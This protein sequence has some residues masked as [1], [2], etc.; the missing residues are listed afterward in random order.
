MGAQ[1]AA[2]GAVMPYVVIGALVVGAVIIYREEIGAAGAAVGE[3]AAATGQAVTDT[4]EAVITGYSETGNV[5]SRF[6]FGRRT[7]QVPYKPMIKPTGSL[8]EFYD[9]LHITGPADPGYGAP[10]DYPTVITPA[11]AENMAA[12]G[13]DIRAAQEDYG[14]V[15]GA[16]HNIDQ[17][18]QLWGW[19]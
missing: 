7:I 5:V 13:R 4:G 14:V 1:E 15:G 10:I 3:A 8:K 9:S 11:Q 6:L 18:W 12:A 16:L 2:I 19:K 17:M